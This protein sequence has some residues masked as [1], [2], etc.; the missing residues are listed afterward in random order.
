MKTNNKIKSF[1][2]LN[3]DNE[4]IVLKNRKI[5]KMYCF[6]LNE[7]KINFKINYLPQGHRIVNCFI[8]GVL[9]QTTKY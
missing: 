4:I 3:I 9:T 6:Y 5:F 1:Y 2:E 8:D 7:N